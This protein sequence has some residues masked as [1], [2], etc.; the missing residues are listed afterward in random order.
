MPER[1]IDA[2]QRS[3]KTPEHLYVFPICHGD[4]GAS[5]HPIWFGVF[6]GHQYICQAF[7]CLSVHTFVSQL[8]TFMPIF[9]HH[10]GL[11]LY[12]TG[13]LWM[14]AMLLAVVPFFVVFIMSQASTTMAMTTTPLVTVVSSGMLSLLSTVTMA[15]SSWGFQQHQA[16]MMW[17]CQHH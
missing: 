15:P 17:F 3:P 12:W 5:V 9:P 16:S 2:L 10:C 11:L 6:G 7:W 13:C 14:S 4:L 8:I 1:C